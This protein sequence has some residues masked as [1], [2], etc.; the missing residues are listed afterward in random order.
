MEH[1]QKLL[2]PLILLLLNVGQAVAVADTTSTAIP[3]Y[4]AIQKLSRVIQFETV[5]PEPG[6]LADA[7]AFTALHDYLEDA[8]PALHARLQKDVINQHSL[9]YTWHGTNPDAN[10]ILLSAHLDVVPV[11]EA[12]RTDWRF[13]PFQGL[14]QEGYIWGRGTMDDKYR[15][16]A[17]MEAVEQL[18]LAGYQPERTL[19]LA[20][21]HDEETGGEAGAGG[22]AAYLQDQ[23][24]RLEAV[25]D[26]GL[27]VAKN[28]M[29]GL[30]EPIAFVGTAAKGNL[31][32]VLEVRGEGGHSSVPVDEPP[33]YILSAAI[34][35]LHETPFPA[36]M[37]PVTKETVARL[38]GKLGGRY[39]FAMQHYGVFRGRVLKMLAQDRVTA[40]LVRTQMAPTVIGGGLKANILPRVAS[41]V[42]N[43]RLLEGDTQ[44]RVLDHAT[45][46]IADERVLVSVQGQYTPPSAVTPTD[47]WTYQA[48]THAIEET[49]PEVQTVVPALFPG[50]TDARHYAGL[51]ANIYRFAPQVVDRQE[52]KRVHNVNERLSV[53]VF[54]KCI[55]FYGHLIRATCGAETQEIALQ[56]EEGSRQ[57]AT[58]AK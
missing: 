34:K 27:A 40:A 43:V 3:A 26:E 37:T 29:P 1:F 50:A 49:F 24:I 23:G 7:E 32:L 6:Q 16:V 22:I 28:I 44:Q 15:V 2:I 21:G 17:M 41:A 58:R 10:P 42:I 31:N 47:G 35:R 11:E 9:L 52:A 56:E 57:V 13:P 18:V 4:P 14:V 33:I 8:F 39:K 55:A 36:R 48:L 5:A 54:G 19:Y 38:A 30:T 45:K 12:T 46:A 53:E 20:F 25:F 51:T